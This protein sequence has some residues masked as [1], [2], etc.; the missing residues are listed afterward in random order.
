MNSRPQ[1]I[2]CENS[3]DELKPIDYKHIDHH[4]ETCVSPLVME[5]ISISSCRS[6]IRIA[7]S[8]SPIFIV[9]SQYQCYEI[10]RHLSLVFVSAKRPITGMSSWE[11]TT[12]KTNEILLRRK[13]PIS[14]I[15]FVFSILFRVWI[16]S[17][18]I[19][20]VSFFF[21]NLPI[22]KIP[23]TRTIIYDYYMNVTMTTKRTRRHTNA[24]NTR[25]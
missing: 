10:H 9:F 5:C 24:A 21:L 18:E 2:V 19:K 6:L 25:E 15:N 8:R 4:H 22:F 17:I 20:L 16:G 23:A 3:R 11:I 7:R 1:D 14:E 12:N 13:K